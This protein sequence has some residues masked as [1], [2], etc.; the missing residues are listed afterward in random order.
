[1]A[2]II[3]WTIFHKWSYL[4]WIKILQICKIF[5]HSE[6]VDDSAEIEKIRFELYQTE[7][8]PGGKR[9]RR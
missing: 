8:T 6:D 3:S 1:M 2:N 7:I 5:K 4:R 9:N